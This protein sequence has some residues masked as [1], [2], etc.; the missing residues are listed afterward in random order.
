MPLAPFL[1]AIWPVLVEYTTNVENLSPGA[2]VRPLGL[3]VLA[4][5]LLVLACL[6]G[7]PDPRGAGLVASAGVLVFWGL[8]ALLEL[9][10]LLGVGGSLGMALAPAVIVG[11]LV[12]LGRWLARHPPGDPARGTAHR[13]LTGF[14]VV[15]VGLVGVQ[16]LGAEWAHRPPPRPPAPPLVPAPPGARP[17]VY[18]VVLDAY[19]RDDYLAAVYGFD[20]RPFLRAL[21]DRGFVVA[22]EAQAGYAWTS[23]SV[24][25]MLALDDHHPEAGAPLDFRSLAE[26]VRDSRAL[27]AFQAAGYQGLVVA[28]GDWKFDATRFDLQVPS[29]WQEFEVLL[30][31]RSALGELWPGA[32]TRARRHQLQSALEAWAPPPPGGPPRFALVHLLAPHP[33]FV[34]EP[35]GGPG[36]TQPLFRLN[37]DG[38]ALDR[39][40]GEGWYRRR[41]LEQLRWLNARVLERIDALVARADRDSVVLLVGDHGARGFLEARHLADPVRR[42]AE[43][44]R[45]VMS[46]LAAYRVPPGVRARL[47]AGTGAVNAM[48]AVAGELLGLPLPPLP[49]RSFLSPLR[50]PGDLVEVPRFGRLERRGPG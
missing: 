15:L 16:A 24:A 28:C 4:T 3:A 38:L 43:Q 26:G 32:F 37:D 14:A 6:G 30:Y 5:S 19:L 36:D 17:D 34:F 10:R 12:T 25:A 13:A 29:H 40:A 46:V 8:G 23:L 45:E 47:D 27:R 44:V 20:N 42:Q 11:L 41:Y 50:R 9:L 21:E 1:L 33:P 48:R 49:E 18:L 7:T 39:V 31:G 2:L 22:R 35:G